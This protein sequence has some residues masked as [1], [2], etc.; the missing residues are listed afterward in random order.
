MVIL[1]T[2]QLLFFT[3]TTDYKFCF[4]INIVF[5]VSSNNL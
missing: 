2:T 5:I 1:I 3:L 4:T